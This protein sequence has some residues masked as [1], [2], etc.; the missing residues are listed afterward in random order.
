M[1]DEVISI[2]EIL[3]PFRVTII[4]TPNLDGNKSYKRSLVVQDLT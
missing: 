2:P 1:S 4:G 3:A